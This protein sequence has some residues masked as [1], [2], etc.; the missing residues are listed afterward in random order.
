LTEPAKNGVNNYFQLIAEKR[1]GDAEK[2]LDEIKQT[3]GKSEQ[4]AGYLKALEGL[5]LTFRTGNDGYLYLTNTELTAKNVELLKKEFSEQSASPLHAG[6]DR[7][8]FTALTEFMKVVG[9][10]RPWRNQQSPQKKEKTKEEEPSETD[11]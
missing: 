8:Y 9:R 5:L 6:Y 2:K 1:L 3:W 4:E 7:G 10:L 11:A